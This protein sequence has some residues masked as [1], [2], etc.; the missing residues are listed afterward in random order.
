[1]G[2]FRGFVELAL[3][4]FASLREVA[5][6]VVAE[7]ARNAMPRPS[8]MRPYQPTVSDML[9]AVSALLELRDFEAVTVDY[10]A[11]E[12]TMEIS[13]RH[14]CGA[15]AV[16]AISD[17]L[18]VS[19]APG[20]ALLAAVNAIGCYCVPRNLVVWGNPHGEPQ[21]EFTEGTP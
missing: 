12:A 7:A 15:W 18:L 11:A 3:E 9:R 19:Y 17:R 13:A 14:R 8:T 10:M 20:G 6:C 5:K 16:G 1:M 2:P 21:P 4:V